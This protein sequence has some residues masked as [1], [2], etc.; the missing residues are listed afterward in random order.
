MCL[1]W[2]LCS[3]EYGWLYTFYI[4]GTSEINVIR[5]AN[6]FSNAELQISA[7]NPFLIFGNLCHAGYNVVDML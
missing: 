3:Q 5:P 2:S 4:H 6:K 1:N 7:D